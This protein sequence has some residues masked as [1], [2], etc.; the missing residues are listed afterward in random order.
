MALESPRIR[1][2]MIEST[3]FPHLAQKYTVFGV[4]KT[5]M[6]E[7]V[8]LEGGTSEDAFLQSVLEAAGQVKV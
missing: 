2:E 6:N 3:E 8:S 4:P 1:A 5:I 7:T